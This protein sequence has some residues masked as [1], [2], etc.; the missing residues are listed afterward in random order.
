[1]KG[2]LSPT[3]EGERWEQYLEIGPITPFCITNL[4]SKEL[5][6]SLSLRYSAISPF[7]AKEREEKAGG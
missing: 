1:M 3:C 2:Q 6:L 7:E 5:S 4:Q